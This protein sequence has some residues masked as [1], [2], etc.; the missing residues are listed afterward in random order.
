MLGS[1]HKSRLEQYLRLDPIRNAWAQRVLGYML[2]PEAR[3]R[4]QHLDPRGGRLISR[5]A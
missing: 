3:P 2:M 5:L 4:L 1:N